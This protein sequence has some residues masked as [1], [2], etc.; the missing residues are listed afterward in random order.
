MYSVALQVNAINSPTSFIF[1]RSLK[2][3]SCNCCYPEP[4][5]RT[6]PR[7]WWTMAGIE[8][9]NVLYHISPSLGGSGMNCWCSTVVNIP[10]Q[11]DFQ[12]NSHLTLNNFTNISPILM[13][14]GRIW[15]SWC[16]LSYYIMVGGFWHE[17]AAQYSGEFCPSG[18]IS[19]E[20]WSDLQ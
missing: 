13:S 14:Q 5:Y 3:T 9:P 10:P 6:N 16:F 8:A 17:L 2:L 18:W 7:F 12:Q 11:V 4:I 1:L 20:S 19:A 15:S